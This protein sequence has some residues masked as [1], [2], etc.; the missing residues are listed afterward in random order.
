MGEIT[1]DDWAPNA[2]EYAEGFGPEWFEPVQPL[3]ANLTEVFLELID[4]NVDAEPAVEEEG[5]C[6]H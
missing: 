4:Q 6:H 1:K 3:N 2:W 5:E